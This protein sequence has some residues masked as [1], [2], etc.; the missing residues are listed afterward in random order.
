M[1]PR[2]PAILIKDFFG[3]NHNRNCNIKLK[4]LSMKQKSPNIS[5]TFIYKVRAKES[6]LKWKDQYGWP[7]CT[8]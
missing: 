5:K 6:L 7:P 2:L 1:P 4:K 8:N 3:K